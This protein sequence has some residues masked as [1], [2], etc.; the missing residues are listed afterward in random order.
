[1][2]VQRLRLSA[3]RRRADSE[4]R[5]RVSPA[6]AGAR[7]A[8]PGPRR[9]VTRRCSHSDSV[10]RQSQAGGRS[11]AAVLPLM[12]FTARPRGLPRSARRYR[13]AQDALARKALQ[14]EMA[15]L[16]LSTGTLAG[17]LATACQFLDCACGGTISRDVLTAVCRRPDPPKH[18]PRP[19]ADSER[20][21]SMRNSLSNIP[22]PLPG[23]THG[24]A[25]R[26]NQLSRAIKS[27]PFQCSNG[28][29]S[30]LWRRSGSAV[31]G[32]QA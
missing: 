7:A 30:P 20:N 3:A 13:V 11:P 25:A 4:L 21:A 16:S 22:C 26:Y 31:W 12:P 24:S 15:A 9:T 2:K 18:G 17:R 32:E 27:K 1:M 8:G 14:P 28:R 19:A 6:V 29:D 23:A 10:G 5:L